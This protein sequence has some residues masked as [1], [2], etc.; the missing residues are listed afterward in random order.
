MLFQLI[1]S[2]IIIVMQNNVYDAGG[3]NYYYI[4]WILFVCLFL[5]WLVCFTLYITLGYFG[6]FLL[7]IQIMIVYKYL[8]YLCIIYYFFIYLYE[9]IFSHFTLCS[10]IIFNIHFV[11]Y[12][13]LIPHLKIGLLCAL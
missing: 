9:F 5:G 8:F 4:I 12:L 11:L 6:V 3:N 1:P 13:L 2:L 7:K 10:S